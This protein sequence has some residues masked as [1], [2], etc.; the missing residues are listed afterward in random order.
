[1]R[2]PF[3][4]AALVVML[5]IVLL[6]VGALGLLR[7][8][9]G[10]ANSLMQLVADD[11]DLREALDEVDEDEL[12]DLLKQERP[13]GMAIPYMATLDGVL[14]FTVGLVGVSLLLRERVHGRIQGISTL[15]FSIVIIA[16]A[17]AMILAAI[18]LVLLM[19]ALLTAV[20]FGTLAYL[21]I[22]GFFN[23]PGANIALSLLMTLKLVFAAL[24]IAAQQRFLQNKGLV[25]L[26][27]TSLLATIIIK[28]LH[29]IVPLILVSITDGIAAIIVAILAL[30]W[31]IFLLIGAIPAVIRILKM[32]GS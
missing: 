30:L 6:E 29:G 26:I 32:Q 25:F 9:A 11:P 16:A 13:P 8:P 24:L 12:E 14:L 28:F 10:Q 23:R 2:K 18:A 22:Y 27:L 21:A 7:S 31:A 17:I 3:F 4:I 19:I 20:P 15:I 5:V 1:M